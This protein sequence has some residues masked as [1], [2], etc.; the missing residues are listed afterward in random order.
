MKSLTTEQVNFFETN[1]YLIIPQVVSSPVLKEAQQSYWNILDKCLKNIYTEY[2]VENQM[3]DYHVFGIERIFHPTIY[4]PS[5][6][7][8]SIESGALEF[9]SQLLN[10]DKTFIL[11]NRIHCT[12]NFSYSGPWHRDGKIGQTDHIQ[13][14]IF[15]YPEDRFFVIPGSHKKKFDEEESQ[16]VNQLW[17]RK[18]FQKQVRLKANA[19]DILLFHSSILHRG[20]CVG[21]EGK[22]RAYIHYRIGKTDFTTD[23]S[24][25]PPEYEL[26]KEITGI[27]Q[28]WDEA[29]A[30]TMNS[31]VPQIELITRLPLQKNLRGVLKKIFY[32][33][34]YYGLSFL[35]EDH[36]L[37][38]RKPNFTPYLRDE[39]KVKK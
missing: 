11:L 31:N 3:S 14:A 39:Y 8:A 13:T 21:R 28:N 16:I 22:N 24:M 19:G 15:L 1:G 6:F 33:F 23:I 36:P 35:D 20:S 2:R 7:K 5:I 4:E 30:R 12:N 10:T 9:S 17:S 34:S 27:D 38:T 25:L 37:F 26:N 29:I 18:H 32:R